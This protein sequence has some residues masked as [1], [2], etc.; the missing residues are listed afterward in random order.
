M[1]FTVLNSLSSNFTTLQL[2]V[3]HPG[4]DFLETRL[5]PR[6]RQFQGIR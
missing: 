2:Y 1:S 5:I 6:K 3:S 4:A